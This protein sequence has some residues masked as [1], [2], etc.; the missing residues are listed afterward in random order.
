MCGL[1]SPTSPEG[2]CTQPPQLGAVYTCPPHL[3][4][5]C[6]CPLHLEAVCTCPLYLEAVCTCSLHLGAM[7]HQMSACVSVLGR[8][9]MCHL[10]PFLPAPEPPSMAQSQTPPGTFVGLLGCH[11]DPTIYSLEVPMR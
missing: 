2:P 3:E 1:Y 7:N 9:W 4:A 6:T 5:V 11:L 8:G 10:Q